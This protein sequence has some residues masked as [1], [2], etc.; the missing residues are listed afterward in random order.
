LALSLTTFAIFGFKS[1]LSQPTNPEIAALSIVADE[2][3]TDR[4]QFRQTGRAS[5]YG[6]SW[7]HVTADGE[8]FDDQNFTAAHRTLPFNTVVRVTNLENSYSVILRINDRGPYVPG[9]VL[10][11]TARAA[12]AL[13]M[14]HRGVV[15]VLIEA[16]ADSTPER[17]AGAP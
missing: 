6:G 7:R 1:A 5:W 15:A 10:D 2:G 16:I 13:G 11:L 9:R 14:K 17:L 8:R 4:S 12:D 3:R